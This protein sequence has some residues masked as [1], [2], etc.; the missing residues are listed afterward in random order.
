[1][2]RKRTYGGDAC[3]SAFSPPRP[4]ADSPL[5][6]TNRRRAGDI[7]YAPTIFSPENSE[8]DVSDR[9]RIAHDF[10]C[11]GHDSACE[12]GKY[13][14]RPRI[15]E[16]PNRLLTNN[17][18]GKL[19]TGTRPEHTSKLGKVR[20]WKHRARLHELVETVRLQVSSPREV[21]GWG[22]VG[23]DQ[24][25]YPMDRIKDPTR[26]SSG[27][28][29]GAVNLEQCS[30]PS[31]RLTSQASLSFES[32]ASCACP[33]NLLGG[34]ALSKARS[35]GGYAT[36][37]PWA[38]GGRRPLLSPDDVMSGAHV[39]LTLRQRGK[40]KTFSVCGSVTLGDKCITVSERSSG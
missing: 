1:M 3:T 38:L 8:L 40:N 15:N 22:S 16:N 18:S 13:W 17:N 35:F 9:C 14:A 10:T 25:T 31:S 2:G 34:P 21:L 5:P 37:P 6:A 11:Y 23:A 30:G 12:L 19:F 29:A 27:Q 36:D 39:M 4:R 20:L 26:A 33:P 28:R 7:P 24:R 32:E